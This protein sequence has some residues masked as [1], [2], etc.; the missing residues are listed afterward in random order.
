[1]TPTIAALLPVDDALQSLALPDR[2]LTLHRIFFDLYAPSLP[3]NA[4]IPVA[5]VLCGGSGEFTIGVRLLDPSGREVARDESR[6]TA[7]AM[8][9]HLFVLRGVLGA[10]GE[11]RLIGSL[12]DETLDLPLIVAQV[13][14]P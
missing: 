4:R 6:F 5:V 2:R 1:M 14:G 3:A 10:P 8:H 7:S 13:G 12:E 9:V 11:Y